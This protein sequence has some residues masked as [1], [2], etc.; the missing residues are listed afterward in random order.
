MASSVIELGEGSE[1]GTKTGSDA[2]GVDCAMDGGGTIV[3]GTVEGVETA[4]VPG[5]A[6]VAPPVVATGCD[7]SNTT[8]SNGRL[9]MAVG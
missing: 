5:V 4:L 9:D 2:E 1:K 7:T 3:G 8:S 6:V